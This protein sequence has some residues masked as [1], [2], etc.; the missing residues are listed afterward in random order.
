MLSADLSKLI[1]IYSGHDPAGIDKS[2]GTFYNGPFAG[3]AVCMAST[4][5]WLTWHETGLKVIGFDIHSEELAWK[6]RDVDR[7]RRKR[8]GDK[9]KYGW[10]SNVSRGIFQEGCCGRGIR[11]THTITVSIQ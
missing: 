11:R 1:A 8:S 9:K 5:L 6:K 2:C 7:E 4:K 3:K 10:R